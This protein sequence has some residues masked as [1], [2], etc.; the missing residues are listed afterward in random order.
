MITTIISWVKGLFNKS[1]RKAMPA[2][3]SA[4]Q[5]M[6]IINDLADNR[7]AWELAEEYLGKWSSMKVYRK[8]DQEVVL[9][10]QGEDYHLTD[11]R[12]AKGESSWCPDEL[13]EE[14]V[15]ELDEIWFYNLDVRLVA[16]MQA[17]ADMEMEEYA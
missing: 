1:S 5:A 6:E 11:V 3:L 2:Q 17:A 16:A 8:A 12:V 15:A 13:S 9:V 4:E 14:L 7:S 10:R